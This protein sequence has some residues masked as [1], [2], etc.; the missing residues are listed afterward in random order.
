[1]Y[2]EGSPGVA[3][4]LLPCD[5]EVVGSSL[6]NS[7]LQ[8]Q[9]NAAYIRPFLKTCASRSYMHRDALNHVKSA[10]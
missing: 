6:R 3:V 8:M 10:V 5:H 7:L 2:H 4:K 9:G 1:M